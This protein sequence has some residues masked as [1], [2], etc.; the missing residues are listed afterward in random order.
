MNL[1]DFWHTPGFKRNPVIWLRS[2]H[3]LS[4][5]SQPAVM[6]VW[7]HCPIVSACGAVNLAADS[8]SVTYNLF[9]VFAL[10]VPVVFLT[11]QKNFHLVDGDGLDLFPA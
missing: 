5:K 6:C 8:V 7:G 3:V 1:Y 9:Q 11:I 2:G 10:T 4:L